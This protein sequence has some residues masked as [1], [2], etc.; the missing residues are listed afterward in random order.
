[1]QKGRKPRRLPTRVYR[2]QRSSYA[3]GGGDRHTQKNKYL[4]CSKGFAYR[5]F[6]LLLWG[7]YYYYLHL[8]DEN[9]VSIRVWLG[10]QK[11]LYGFQ[12]GKRETK[13][14]LFIYLDAQGS[15]SWEAVP[16]NLR[17]IN[18]VIDSK[19]SPGS[20]SKSNGSL[21]SLYPAC[22]QVTLKR[23]VGVWFHIGPSVWLWLF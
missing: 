23:S 7:R 18:E 22:Q 3:S 12:Y 8:T 20:H 16:N 4:I 15:K 5:L 21:G 6:H 14:E 1:M 2:T 17:I 9:T 10:E 13:Q 19:S 11:P